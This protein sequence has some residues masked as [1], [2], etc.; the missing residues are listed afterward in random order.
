MKDKEIIQQLEP[1]REHYG[2]IKAPAGLEDRLLQGVRSR[3][4]QRRRRRRR[5]LVAASLSIAAALA[6][7][8]FLQQ[9]ATPSPSLD[10][11]SDEAIVNYLH[12]TH[13]P[14]GA[15]QLLEN[16]QSFSETDINLDQL[17]DADLENYLLENTS[18]G[19]LESFYYN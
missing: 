8:L 17:S 3:L 7:G 14:F 13:R 11:L 16:N 6:L 2:N 19:E 1:L 4:E 18:T 10:Q 9:P 15:E 12:T 5:G